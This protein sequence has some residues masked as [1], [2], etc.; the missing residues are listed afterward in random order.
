MLDLGAGVEAL[1]RLAGFGQVLRPMGSSPSG[2]AEF[3][4]EP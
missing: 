4:L 2:A 1:Q 3:Q